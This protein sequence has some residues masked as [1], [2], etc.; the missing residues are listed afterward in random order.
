MSEDK[1]V[2]EKN[3]DTKPAVKPVVKPVPAKPHVDIR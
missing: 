3:T 1:K 2:K